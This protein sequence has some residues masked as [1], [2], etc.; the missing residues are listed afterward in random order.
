MLAAP[1]TRLALLLALARY[2]QL[3][4]LAA[5][6]AAPLQTVNELS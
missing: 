4:A 1:Y 3:T 2:L 6:A 5:L